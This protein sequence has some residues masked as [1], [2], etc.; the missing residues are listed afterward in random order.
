M[1]S[2]GPDE[3]AVLERDLERA[4]ERPAAVVPSARVGI[5]RAYE[6]LGVPRGA[7]ILVSGFNYP[8]LVERLRRAGWRPVAVDVAPGETHPSVAAYAAACT[9]RTA[10]MLAT[11]AF[12]RPAP[13]AGYRALADRLGLV[14]VEDAAQALGADV[15]RHGHATVFSFGPTKPLAGWG[16]GA[17][18]GD[19]A[20]VLRRRSRRSRACASRVLRGLA[21][22]CITRR[23]G[24]ALR[25]PIDWDRWTTDPLGA[26]NRRPWQDAPLDPAC[27]ALMRARVPRLR[28]ITA[29][30]RRA[31]VT[32]SAQLTAR[33]LDVLDDTG[34]GF[35]ALVLHRRPRWLARAL[36]AEGVDAACGELR[37]LPGCARAAWLER[38]LVRIPTPPQL[39]SQSASESNASTKI[40]IG[41]SR[42]SAEPTKKSRKRTLLI[43]SA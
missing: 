12:G 18:L 14:L 22:E 25:A 39:S 27:A 13:C 40:G 21:F 16:G 6:A 26:L 38:S 7:E 32:V 42:P 17:V 36:R 3:V 9:D 10:A 5:V 1:A 2:A 23:G 33:G 4:L 28:A 8:P 31:H 11:H 34:I 15:G 19:A 24:V 43:A 30:R 41:S 35:G 37:A 29:A 20:L